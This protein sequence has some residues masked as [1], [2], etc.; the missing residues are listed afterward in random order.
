MTS[1]AGWYT[2]RDNA[3]DSHHFLLHKNKGFDLDRN[4]FLEKHSRI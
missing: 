2:I 1:H 3:R 4:N